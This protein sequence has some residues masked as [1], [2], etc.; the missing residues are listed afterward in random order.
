VAVVS[1]A[2]LVNQNIGE[3]LKDLSHNDEEIM[4]ADCQ[5]K[6]A[7]LATFAPSLLH[8]IDQE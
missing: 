8:I 7:E 2:V 6:C 3:L 1:H 5:Q 4:Q